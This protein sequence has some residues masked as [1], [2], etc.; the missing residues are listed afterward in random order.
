MSTT[1]HQYNVFLLDVSGVQPAL[2]L[3]TYIHVL[4]L[5]VSGEK[6]ALQL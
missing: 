3:N 2:Q 4:L 6:V 5:D 1:V